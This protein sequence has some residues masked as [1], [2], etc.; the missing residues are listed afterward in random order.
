MFTNTLPPYPETDEEISGTPFA[1]HQ[2]QSVF[3]TSSLSVQSST[4]VHPS[5]ILTVSALRGSEW[6]SAMAE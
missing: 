1:L 5:N 6:A 3:P 4:A 2:S